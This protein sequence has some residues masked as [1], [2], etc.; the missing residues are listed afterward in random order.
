MRVNGKVVAVHCLYLDENESL[1]SKITPRAIQP[2]HDIVEGLLTAA[3]DYASGDPVGQLIMAGISICRTRRM[4]IENEKGSLV[5]DTQS[6]L[7]F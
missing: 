7:P 5:I 6:E 1:V 3:A 2:N 4:K